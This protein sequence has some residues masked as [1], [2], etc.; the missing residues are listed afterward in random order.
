M[1]N[2]DAV[3]LDG[4][5]AALACA[6]C[7][8]TLAAAGMLVRCRACR[9]VVLCEACIPALVELDGVRHPICAACLRAAYHATRDEGEA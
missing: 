7:G 6:T 2:P 5:A 1:S 3:T 9:A 4:G 8:A